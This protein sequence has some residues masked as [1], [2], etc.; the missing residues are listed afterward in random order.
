MPNHS[1]VTLVDHALITQNG[2]L[3]IHLRIHTGE[4]PFKCDTCGLRFAV[5]GSL[6][7]HM[8][9][10]TEEKPYNCD[11]CGLCFTHNEGL[12]YHLQI[13]S[14]EKPFKCDTCG[15]WFSRI[16]IRS[17]ICAHILAKKPLNVISVDYALL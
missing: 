17:Y 11:T 15:L 1:N 9:T 16:G 13:H 3:T 5:S 6:K 8:R 4:K 7:R 2:S 10:H 12:K 14:R